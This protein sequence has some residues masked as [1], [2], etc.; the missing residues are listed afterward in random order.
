MTKGVR[1]EVVGKKGQGEKRTE[2]IGR[3]KGKM[4]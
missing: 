4:R 3:K 1:G 2:K